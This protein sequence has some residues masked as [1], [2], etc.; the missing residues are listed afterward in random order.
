MLPFFI[1]VFH[2]FTQILELLLLIF[3]Y[4]LLHLFLFLFSRGNSFFRYP[5]FLL[6]TF[7]HPTSFLQFLA[8]LFVACHNSSRVFSSCNV[9]EDLDLCL[10][11]SSN[12]SAFVPLKSARFKCSCLFPF[13]SLTFVIT[14]RRLWSLSTYLSISC[15]LWYKTSISIHS[16]TW[17][18]LTALCKLSSLVYRFWRLWHSWEAYAVQLFMHTHTL[19]IGHF[20]GKCRLVAMA[21]ALCLWCPMM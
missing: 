2:L 11:S 21:G 6:N 13:A 18:M 10:T 3:P 5:C 9:S 12:V 7:L 19:F 4:C 20:P 16:L 1:C 14:T 15:S 8:G 17:W